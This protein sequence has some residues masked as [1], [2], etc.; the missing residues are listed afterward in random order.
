MDQS[1]VDRKKEGENK[2]MERM[3]VDSPHQIA[4]G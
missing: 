1:T 2:I 3:Y 4:K